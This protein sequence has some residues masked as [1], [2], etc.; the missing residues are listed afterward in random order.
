MVKSSIS[1]VKK[2]TFL[3]IEISPEKVIHVKI[4]TFGQGKVA[5]C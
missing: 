4:L 3:S 2:Q 5:V 1:Y